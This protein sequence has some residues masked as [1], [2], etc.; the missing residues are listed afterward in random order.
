MKK[1]H[2]I[3]ASIL[4][5]LTLTGC[6]QGVVI[7][8]DAEELE[9]KNVISLTLDA[10]ALSLDVGDTYLFK[11][12]VAVKD[13]TI[14]TSLEWKST[15]NKIVSISQDG[16]AMAIKSGRA[17]ISC[18][19]GLKFAQCD[20]TV[21]GDVIYVDEI[22]YLALNKKDIYLTPGSTE[23][24][25]YQ[26]MPSDVTIQAAWSSSDESVAIVSEYG[27]V[28]AKA[29][30]D[31]VVTIS[32]KEFSDTCTIHVSDEPYVPVFTMTISDELATLTV[33]Q[34]K[35]LSVTKSAPAT[36]S[37]RSNNNTVAKVDENGLVTAQSEGNA[38][39]IASANGVEVSCAVSVVSGEE[40]EGHKV[41]VFFFIDY[42]N[43]FMDDETGE[44]LLMKL[45]W[46]SEKL[47]TVKPDNPTKAPDPAFPYF[48]GWSTHTIID[49][50]ADLWDF[51]K[52]VVRYGIYTLKLYGIWSDVEDFNL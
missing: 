26:T 15:N 14:A 49:S 29:V 28:T 40:E 16:V 10:K 2:T 7:D 20:I 48:V 27:N 3:L 32:Y 11:P 34:T 21:S 22:T 43:A 18:F 42:N 9:N 41:T 8:K 35:Q 1:N 38:R 46:R 30:G 5:A 33:G 47:I 31:A 36:V 23:Q 6:T 52:D 25:A 12:E 13:D 45:E 39:I 24:L 50:K 17:T 4:L 19:A 44:Y 37:W 51:S